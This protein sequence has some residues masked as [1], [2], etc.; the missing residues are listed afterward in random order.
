[1][2]SACSALPPTSTA[3]F[4]AMSQVY[5]LPVATFLIF[6]VTFIGT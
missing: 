4:A 1:V 5:L 6:Q 2:A 3:T